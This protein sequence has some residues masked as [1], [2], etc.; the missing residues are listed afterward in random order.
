MPNT[1]NSRKENV[2]IISGDYVTVYDANGKVFYISTDD[3][4]A[5]RLCYWGVHCNGYVHGCINSKSISL[6]KYLM[7][8]PK[9]MEVDHINHNHN[10]CRRSNMRVCE[11]KNNAK[12]Q[13]V[14]IS[15]TS[16]YKGVDFH[17]S[18]KR[19]RARIRVNNRRIDL[20]YFRSPEEAYEAYKKAS[21]IYHGEYAFAP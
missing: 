17:K 10:D 3:L 4:E 2:Y 11:H 1:T 14:Q 18:V 13:P 6:H 16:G 19:W 9:G 7:S 21:T 15:N 5:V 12:N 20:G 8:P